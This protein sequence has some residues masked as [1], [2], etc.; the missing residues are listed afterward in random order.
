YEVDFVIESGRNCMAIEV[1]SSARW[2]KR[3]LSGLEAFIAATPHCRAAVLCYNGEEAV[4]LG[5]NIWALPLGL[6]LS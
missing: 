1:K 2:E 4:R 3:D 6:V 5:D